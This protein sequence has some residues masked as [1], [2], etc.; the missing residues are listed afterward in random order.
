M[1]IPAITCIHLC[2]SIIHLGELYRRQSRWPTNSTQLLFP[3]STLSHYVFDQSYSPHIIHVWHHTVISINLLGCCSCLLF[4]S[5]IRFLRCC[6]SLIRRVLMHQRMLCS[7]YVSMWCF[8]V[9]YLHLL[10][11]L[12]HNVNTV[13]HCIENMAVFGIPAT[14]FYFLKSCSRASLSEAR[15][16]H[17][18]GVRIQP[19]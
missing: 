6:R 13:V 19:S 8:P 4:R 1:T 14:H 5:I 11:V 2:I 15:N 17:R 12:E 7:W 3:G 10:V 16:K 18:V 9:L